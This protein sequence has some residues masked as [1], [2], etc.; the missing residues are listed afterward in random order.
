MKKTLIL[1]VLILNNFLFATGPSYAIVALTPI[2]TH[3]NGNVLFQ[4]YA[5]LN[6]EG[7]SSEK[8]KHGWLVVSANGVWDERVA[9]VVNNL[10]GNPNEE[11]EKRDIA[12]SSGKV[13]L[14]HPDE[15]LKSLMNKYGF[16]SGTPLISEKYKIL[17]L[18]KQQSCYVGRCVNKVLKQKSIEGYVCDNIFKTTRGDDFS[19]KGVVLMHNVTHW[20]DE[21]EQYGGQFNFDDNVTYDSEEIDGIVLLGD[22]WRNK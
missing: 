17:E 5:N 4:T 8:R 10:V 13:N 20:L 11:L 6:K 22:F 7:G 19:Y 15:V 3:E 18:K 9:L 2:A 1:W 14:L 12:Y 16:K 21:V